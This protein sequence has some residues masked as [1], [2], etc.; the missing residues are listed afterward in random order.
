[1]QDLI[2]CSLVGCRFDDIIRR[3]HRICGCGMDGAGS[4]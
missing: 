1:M 2:L 3:V 4:E